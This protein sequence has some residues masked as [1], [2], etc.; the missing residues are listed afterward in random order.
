M[1][2]VF[3]FCLFKLHILVEVS[4]VQHEGKDFFFFKIV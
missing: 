3:F 2:N 4:L 1:A